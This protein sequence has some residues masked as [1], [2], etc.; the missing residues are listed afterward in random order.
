MATFSSCQRERGGRLNF[1]QGRFAFISTEKHSILNPPKLGA[2]DMNSLSDYIKRNA[3][4]RRAED[5]L[6]G[7]GREQQ[8]EALRKEY[9]KLLDNPMAM[10]RHEGMETSFSDG[11]ISNF[12]ERR[13]SSGYRTSF[14]IDASA[15]KGDKGDGYEEVGYF[16]TS[17]T[18][19]SKQGLRAAANREVY[20]F[21]IDEE[22]KQ[23]GISFH[24]PGKANLGQ[25]VV[26]YSELKIERGALADWEAAW[27]ERQRGADGLAANLSITKGDVTKEFEASWHENGSI[28]VKVGGKWESY[29]RFARRELYGK[30][31]VPRFAAFIKTAISGVEAKVADDGDGK[32][33]IATRKIIQGHFR[34][35][36][37]LAENKIKRNSGPR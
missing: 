18:I 17:L 36:R 26:D 30:E 9:S 10:L 16:P 7:V 20:T 28:L 22:K 2:A 31:E 32:G 15:F 19:I 11:F 21:V 23:L 34:A 35:Q 37:I 3:K 29:W 33:F 25:V 5:D 1:R 4:Q 27:V 8:N 13:T 6:S 24:Q 12:S 14:T